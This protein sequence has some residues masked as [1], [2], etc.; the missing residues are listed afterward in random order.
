MLWTLPKEYRRDDWVTELLQACQQALD[1]GVME[2]VQQLAGDILL[3]RMTER[4]LAVE[5]RLC[6]ISPSDGAAIEDRKAAVAARWKTGVALTLEQLQALCD[7][8]R[9]GEVEADYVGDRIVI[10]FVGAYGVP[11]DLAGLK[12]ALEDARPA[13]L[14]VDYLFRYLLV[15]EVSAMTLDQL[16]AQQIKNFA[17]GG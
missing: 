9:N 3:D 7:S 11:D 6:G 2:P 17:F 13:H 5:E 8:W 14:P 1:S 15:R 16:Q 12:A 10:Q 4:Q